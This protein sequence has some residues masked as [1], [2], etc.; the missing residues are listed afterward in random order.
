MLVA[1]VI[2]SVAFAKVATVYFEP[3]IKAVGIFALR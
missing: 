2:F 1:K 3:W